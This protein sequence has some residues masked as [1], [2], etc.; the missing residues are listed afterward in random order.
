[1][2]MLS[3]GVILEVNKEI[4]EIESFL[5]TRYLID[6]GTNL[7]EIFKAQNRHHV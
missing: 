5:K 3:I 6:Q 4:H 7:R 1:M 2:N